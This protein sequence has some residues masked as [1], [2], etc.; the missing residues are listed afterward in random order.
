M[1]EEKKCSHTSVTLGNMTVFRFVFNIPYPKDFRAVGHLR[2][3]NHEK[4]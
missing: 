1:E 3:Y 2:R 4:Y